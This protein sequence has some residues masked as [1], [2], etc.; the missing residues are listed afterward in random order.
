MAPS[1]QFNWTDLV[2]G[3]P[4]NPHPPG[5]YDWASDGHQVDLYPEHTI[6]MLLDPTTGIGRRNALSVARNRLTVSDPTATSPTLASIN[7]TVLFP[8]NSAGTV[9]VTNYGIGQ[10]DIREFS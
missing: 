7:Q 8:T 1:A 10:A 5:R 9:T 2:S 4:I 6:E 3:A